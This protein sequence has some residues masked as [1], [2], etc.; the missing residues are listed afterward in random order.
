MAYLEDQNKLIEQQFAGLRKKNVAQQEEAKRLSAMN[1]A[2]N[3]NASGGFGGAEQKL[4]DESNLKLNQ[5]FAANEGDVTAQE[6]AAKTGLAEAEQ[7]RQFAGSENEKNRAQASDFFN[8]EFGENQRTNMIN[9]VIA[10]RQAGFAN[11]EAWR[12][13]FNSGF[14]ALF[15]ASK[16]VQGALPQVGKPQPLYGFAAMKQ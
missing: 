1:L 7:A 3:A 13:A 11:P 5:A 12:Q 10:L 14:G 2:R 4:Q 16:D 9:S 8:K 6:A 15:P